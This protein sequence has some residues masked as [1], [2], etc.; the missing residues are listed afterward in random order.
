[1]RSLPAQ[2]RLALCDLGDTVARAHR[3]DPVGGFTSVVTF[4]SSAQGS[5][6]PHEFFPCVAVGE[7][8]AAAP[9]VLIAGSGAVGADKG[10]A[11]RPALAEPLTCTAGTRHT[12]AA[13]EIWGL[14]KVS[15]FIPQSGVEYVQPWV[16]RLTFP[17]REAA[18]AASC[19]PSWG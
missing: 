7:A 2:T 6:N 15:K 4:T 17:S 19:S 3:P 1:M 10:I 11:P 9:G 5:V 8:L 16:P 14:Q 18:L 12:P 13:T